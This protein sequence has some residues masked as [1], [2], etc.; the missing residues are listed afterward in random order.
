MMVWGDS[1]V[2]M[3]KRK[4]RMFFFQRHGYQLPNNESS[5]FL[6][7]RGSTA[8]KLEGDDESIPRDECLPPKV[9]DP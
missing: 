6:S 3:G 2:S 5:Q 8:T 1:R 9:D 4:S 7:V